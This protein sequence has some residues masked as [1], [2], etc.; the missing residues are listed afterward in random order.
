MGRFRSRFRRSIG[1]RFLRLDLTKTRV[2]A[3]AGIPGLR[4]SWHSSGR[5]TTSVGVPGTGVSWQK[6]ECTRDDRPRPK[7]LPK[8]SPP[9]GWYPDPTG[10]LDERWWD[11]A[12]WTAQARRGS[13]VVQDPI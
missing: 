2:G 1:N 6:V 5:T 9:S 3:S 12:S 11:G 10:R 7:L 4:K 8:P 13:N